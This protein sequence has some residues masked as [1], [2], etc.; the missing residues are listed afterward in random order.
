MQ[1]GWICP[2]CSKAVAPKEDHY[3][4]CDSPSEVTFW[5]RFDKTEETTN[6]LLRIYEIYG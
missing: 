6:S 1:T 4:S 3:P 2:K 5:P